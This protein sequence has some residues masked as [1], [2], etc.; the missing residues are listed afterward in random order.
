MSANML[1]I[2]CGNQSIMFDP[3]MT[4]QVFSTIATGN[5]ELC[6]CS[7]CLNFAAQR[8]SAYP[9]DFRLLLGQLGIDPE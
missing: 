9:V 1:L 8:H 3:E 5:A 4:K 6:G 7:H 2:Q